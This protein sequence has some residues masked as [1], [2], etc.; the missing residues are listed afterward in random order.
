MGSVPL[1][2]PTHNKKVESTDST[3]RTASQLTDQRGL[4]EIPAVR[5]KKIP[6]NKINNSLIVSKRDQE[7]VIK[8]KVKERTG[9]ESLS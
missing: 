5:F 1:C 8:T 6:L 3:Q 2:E 7:I 9:L 4:I